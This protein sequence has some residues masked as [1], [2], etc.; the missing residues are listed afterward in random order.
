MSGQATGP[1]EDTRVL[2]VEDDR[3]IAESLVRGLRQAGYPVEGV[4]AD[5][6]R[7]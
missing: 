6:D 7:P 1:S 4:R 3:G 2:A 5:R